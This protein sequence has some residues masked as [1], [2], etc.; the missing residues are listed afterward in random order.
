MYASWVV[1]ILLGSNAVAVAAEPSDLDRAIDQA[2]SFLQRNQDTDGAWRGG[3]RNPKSA[4]VTG[5]SVMA[6]LSAGHV[7]SEGRYGKTVDRGIDWVLQQQKPNGLIAGEGGYEMYH[8]GICTLMLAEVAGMIDGRRGEAVRRGLEKAVEVILKAQRTSA[9][10]ANGGWRYHLDARHD[11]PQITDLSVT[12]WQLMALR[13][14]KN[15]GCDVP[16]ERIDQAV[17]YIK[18]CQDP[19]S[20]GYCYDPRRQVTIGCTGTGILALELSGKERHR[21]P[22]ALRAGAYLIRTDHLPRWGQHHFFYSVYY[23]S[24]A[25]FQLGGN[26]W[27]VYQPHLHR[28]L[29]NN[30]NGNGAWLGADGSSRMY[31]P[32][33]C[34]AMGVLALTVEYRLLPIYQR[35]SEDDKVTR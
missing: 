33:Y 17:G 6:F 31:G 34:T 20:G 13:A 3:P 15:L 7:P 32:N 1:G 4:A 14:A 30:Q 25:T 16:P 28:V 18:R 8:H 27:S 22:H 5:L 10:D 23:G 9:G 2:L 24:Q 19:A 21:T 29:L 12:G 35:G 26:Y 11:Q